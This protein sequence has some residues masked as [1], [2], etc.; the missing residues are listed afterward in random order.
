MKKLILIALFILTLINESKG[1]ETTTN[2]TFN[3]FVEWNFGV[4]L[5]GDDLGIDGIF[6]GTSVLW[7]RT[8]ISK[9][10]I[11]FEYQAG[12]ALPSLVTGKIGV[13]RKFNNTQVVLGVRPFPFNTYLQSSFTNKKKGYWIIS[14]EYNPLDSG[15][16]ISFES[17]AI[18]NFGYRWH[19][20]KK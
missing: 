14:L 19:I 2:K 16:D 6:P 1:Q 12:F 17:K 15:S 18:L 11:I 3:S 20:N 7:G 9:N 13:G 4:A 8:Y 5:I 10:D